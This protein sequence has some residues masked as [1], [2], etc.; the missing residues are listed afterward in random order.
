MIREDGEADPGPLTQTVLRI[1]NPH[2][3]ISRI[4]NSLVHLVAVY[5]EMSKVMSSSL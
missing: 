3:E 5:L 1:I 4:W 2:M